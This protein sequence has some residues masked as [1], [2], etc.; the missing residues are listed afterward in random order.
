MLRALYT[1]AARYEPV[2]FATTFPPQFLPPLATLLET[3]PDRETRLL[4]L[5]ILDTLID[6]RDN[7]GKLEASQLLEVNPPNDKK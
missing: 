5:D 2:H 7:L 4:V 1:V 3:G 6:R